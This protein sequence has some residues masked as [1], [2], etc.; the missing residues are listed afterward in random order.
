MHDW[1][2]HVD[3]GN[4]YR[5]CRKCG[6]VEKVVEGHRWVVYVQETKEETNLCC[7][8]EKII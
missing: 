1:Q 3:N 5:H 4:C 6:R 2:F 8:K 7:F